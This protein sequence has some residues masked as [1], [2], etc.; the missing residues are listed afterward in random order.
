MYQDE[1]DLNSAD[2]STDFEEE[3]PPGDEVANE[4]EELIR[5]KK[6]DSDKE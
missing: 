5:R 3:L 1:I 4:I 2:F 6:R